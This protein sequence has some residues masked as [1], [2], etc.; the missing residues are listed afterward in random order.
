MVYKRG[1]AERLP[2]HFAAIFGNAID[3]VVSMSRVLCSRCKQACDFDDLRGVGGVKV[4]GVCA[5]ALLKAATPV[6][7]TTILDRYPPPP[8]EITAAVRHAYLAQNRRGRVWLYFVGALSVLVQPL[9][10]VLSEHYE[11]APLREYVLEPAEFTELPPR[12]VLEQDLERQRSGEPVSYAVTFVYYNALKQRRTVL[13]YLAPDEALAL[14]AFANAHGGKVSVHRP[15]REWF[16]FIGSWEYGGR[17]AEGRMTALNDR[18][19]S[20]SASMLFM[21]VLGWFSA[22]VN[23]W[24]MRR[25]IGVYKR[26]I[27]VLAD[28]ALKVDV[29]Q[30][31][32]FDHA[33]DYFKLGKAWAILKLHLNVL[34]LLRT[35]KH[36]GMLVLQLAKGVE[37]WYLNGKVVVCFLPDKPGQAVLVPSDIGARLA[38][39]HA[40]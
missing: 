18:N 37:P 36:D 21:A 32:L 5:D 14:R 4:C 8:R 10:H 26:G 29:F 27:F 13:R 22:G 7:Q 2:R 16:D 34:Y 38:C 6:R 19:V 31:E 25:K 39:I 9:I 24:W 12:E 11:I 15:D 23:A 30:R 35:P 40:L 17:G 1:E 20:L 3:L 33:M 28:S